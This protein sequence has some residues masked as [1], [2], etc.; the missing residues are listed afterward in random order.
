MALRAALA[1]LTG[2]LV[3]SATELGIAACGGPL[4]AQ[5]A[6]APAIATGAWAPLGNGTSC[7]VAVDCHIRG[8]TAGLEVRDCNTPPGC[9]A[10]QLFRFEASSG[11]L[12]S[13]TTGE[14]GKRWCLTLADVD[15]P[16]VNLWPCDSGS[17]S[18]QWTWD[19]ASSAF[20]TANSRAGH[21]C[22]TRP[23]PAAPIR[24]TAN[25][26]ALS[27]TYH[28]VG[29][30]AAVGGARMLYE[31][32]EPTRSEILDL[33][34]APTGGAAIQ[35]LKV[36]ILGDVD[37]SYGSGPSFQHTKGNIDANRGVYLPWLV[38]EARK[39]Q[40]DIVTYCLS[41]GVPAWVGNGT[42]YSDEG[43]QYHVDYLKA[44]KAAFNETFDYIGVWNEMHWKRSW[45]KQLRSA[46]DD[47]GFNSTVI[48]MPDGANRGCDD[49]PSSWGDEAVSALNHDPELAAAV[50]FLG[51]HTADPEGVTIGSQTLP[52]GV[53]FWD[54][55]D[56]VVDGPQ[57]Q[58]EPVPG[59]PYGSG[60]GWPRVA[61][62]NYV[63]G[64]AT[65]TILCPLMHSWS[66][67]LGRENH[68]LAQV[69][70]PWSGF[71]QL[72]SAFWSQ[73]HLTQLTKVGW[74]FVDGGGSGEVCDGG[75]ER[76]AE[77]F[78]GS[79]RAAAVSS[80]DVVWA[81]LAAPDSSD[82][83]TVAIN[84]GTA[85]QSLALAFTGALYLA[86]ARASPLQ[87]W[88]TN[89]TSWFQP[90]EPVAAPAAQGLP[91]VVPLPPR[92]AVSVSTLRTASRA[93]FVSPPR[94]P[95]AMPFCSDFGSQAHGEPGRMLS[96]IFGA[97]TVE[98]P[99]SWAPKAGSKVLWQGAAA[100]P[101]T[102][103]WH[104]NGNGAPFTLA[105]DALNLA[106]ANVSVTVLLPPSGGTARACGRVPVWQPQAFMSTTAALG[107]CAQLDVPADGSAARLS[108]IE[109]PDLSTEPKTWA[110]VT[111]G[112][113]LA[114]R[115]VVLSLDASGG[116]AA[117]SAALPGSAT[118]WTA[119]TQGPLSLHG[120]AWGFGS[121]WHEAWF[122]DLA[123]TAA[124]GA[125]PS[126][127]GSFLHSL[128]PGTT[129]ARVDGWAGMAVRLSA[130]GA[131]V[132]V[133]SLGRFRPSGSSR[134]HNL[135]VIDAAT[136]LAMLP[137]PVE[138]DL[139]LSG[140]PADALGFVHAELS[141]ALTL[142]AGGTY[143]F[144][145]SEEGAGDVTLEMTD[146]CAGTTHSN[147]DGSTLMRY[148]GAGGGAQVTGRVS[149]DGSA[150]GWTL[151]DG[152]DGVDTSFGPVNF[153][154][155]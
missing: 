115:W 50:G 32:P 72:G 59:Q 48:V 120:G 62:T 63:R 1:V 39:R 75:E 61:L 155:A 84:T 100:D 145:S 144:V 94:G 124:A 112:A 142:R 146:P 147:R 96:D 136:G 41:W 4:S 15:G 5:Q 110:E 140:P 30:L 152:L 49:C 54:S 6:F 67:N 143:F 19:A 87:V 126:T 119:S 82:V 125:G 55:E 51:L 18:T 13:N 150:G 57:P 21:G 11:F 46:L 153:A 24:V 26:S 47:S 7:I 109:T 95:A 53:G 31:Y 85:H 139:G 10:E 22:L 97:F 122:D 56:N 128:L 111:A 129:T 103:A 76:L 36:E 138:V 74:R 83:T 151:V 81:T 9:P 107:V 44:A 133:T 70:E 40:P 116:A 60:L 114:G 121:G 90:G 132:A 127:A 148:S 28:G 88:R 102:N 43:L 154:V 12:F 118:A 69:V 2:A 92:S 108:I 117:A 64:G 134:R 27:A 73:A 135:T 38:Q 58:F 149:G 66:W 113:S 89:V 99:P 141:P 130:S 25:A 45:I 86:A 105:P 29:G 3:A 37:S 93:T 98:T 52:D 20:Q 16:G 71:A 104:S 123:L 68:G 8:S 23:G 131:D 35:I 42:Y 91:V 79:G 101:A 65:A 33:M 14:R 137:H 77:S 78:R 80:C 17:T 106:E 34:F